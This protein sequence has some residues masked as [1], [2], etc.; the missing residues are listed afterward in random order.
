MLKVNVKS[1]MDC[2]NWLAKKR[3]KYCPKDY[4]NWIGIK[5][6]MAVVT[7]G[8]Y[9]VMVQSDIFK[10][11]KILNKDFQMIS[12]KFPS[13]KSVVGDSFSKGQML[14]GIAVNAD[15]VLRMCNSVNA[16]TAFK[17]NLLFSLDFSEEQATP[18]IACEALASDACF[19]VGSV[20]K[21]IEDFGKNEIYEMAYDP[22]K[23]FL[24]V[25]SACRSLCALVAGYVKA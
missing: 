1:E 21:A 20:K 8:F 14:P 4:A 11:E 25:A 17:N 5:D 10:E 3:D 18:I 9:L 24:L 6:Q 2:I 12:G 15:H 7:N 23:G 19:N 13:V 22:K 16:A